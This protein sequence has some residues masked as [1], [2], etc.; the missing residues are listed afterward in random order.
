MSKKYDDS[1]LNVVMIR[2]L[3]HYDSMIMITTKLHQETIKNSLN[4]LFWYY[5]IVRVKSD[6][7]GIYIS[8]MA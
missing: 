1:T 7:N 4:S 6:I 3:I 2:I 8:Y 5:P